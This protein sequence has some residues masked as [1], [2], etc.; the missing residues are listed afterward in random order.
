[1]PTTTPPDRPG[2]PR[3]EQALLDKIGKSGK[4]SANPLSYTLPGSRL[5]RQ[6]K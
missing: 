6:R 3:N 4:L 1:V 5:F 2:L